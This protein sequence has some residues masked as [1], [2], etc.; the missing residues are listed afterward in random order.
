MLSFRHP[1]RRSEIPVAR[2]L[3]HGQ[4]RLRPADGVAATR[5]GRQPSDDHRLDGR[6]RHPVGVHGGELDTPL[7]EVV[8]GKASDRPGHRR[9]DRV[10]ARNRDRVRR[11]PGHRPDGNLWFTE[12]GIPGALGRISPDGPNT[13]TEFS[14]PSN[15]ITGGADGNLWFTQLQSVWRLTIADCDRCVAGKLKAIG[16]KES[17]R[18]AC[19]AKVVRTGDSSE[20]SDCV[21]TV[22]AKYTGAFASAGECGSSDAAC[23]SSVD[24]CVSQVAANLPDAPSRCEASK[25]K[26]V[27]KAVVSLFNCAAKSAV[28]GKPADPDCATLLPG[29]RAQAKLAAAFAKA[30]GSSPCPGDPTLVGLVTDLVCHIQIPVVDSTRTVAG[31]ECF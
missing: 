17:G 10:G 13:I 1:V 12:T 19:L 28:R 30:D 3:T 15:E 5:D 14:I 23:E 9:P 29:T 26:A 25:L 6:C 16:K 2:V 7:D 18:F 27:G 20:L 22:E 31:F 8:D 11:G 24:S 4:P 21:A